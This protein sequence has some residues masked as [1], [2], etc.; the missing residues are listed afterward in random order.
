MQGIKVEN[1]RERKQV[2]L[3]WNLKEVREL[4]KGTS[5]GGALRRKGT[6]RAKVLRCEVCLICYRG[7][8]ATVAAAE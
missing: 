1:R 6:D 7:S 5:K 4:V 3:S 8:K 2:T